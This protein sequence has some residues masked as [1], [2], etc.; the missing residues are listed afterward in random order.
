[1]NR[2]RLMKIFVGLLALTLIPGCNRSPKPGDRTAGSD[3]QS[4]N[5]KGSITYPP[6]LLPAPPK[7][8]SVSEGTPE[9]RAAKFAD[10]LASRETRLSGWLGVYDALRI[11]VIRQDGAAVGSTGDDPI[12]PRFWQVWYAS[13]LDLA[14]RGIP[15]NDAGRLMVVGLP[16]VDG[17]AFGEV[18]LKDLRLALQSSDPQERLLGK[19]VR[20]RVLRGS[21]GVDLANPAVTPQAAVI[22]LPTVQLLGWIAIRGV[23]FQAASLS[24]ETALA[25]PQT[26]AAYHLAAAL[27][28]VLGQGPSTQL[29]ELPQEP[30]IAERPCS[31]AFGGENSAYW[32][33]W[34]TNTI[35]GK[36]IELP[37]EYGKGLRGLIQRILIGGGAGEHTFFGKN[38]LPDTKFYQPKIRGES[39]KTVDIAGKAVHWASGLIS[40]LALALQISALDINPHQ[41]EPLVRTHSTSDGNKGNIV[42]VLFS[43]TEQPDDNADESKSKLHNCMLIYLSSMFGVS[44]SMPP[45][46]KIPGAAVKFKGGKGFPDLV[47]FGDYRDLSEAGKET[48]A[49]GE[50]TLAIIGKAQKRE[51]PKSAKPVDKEFSIFVSAQPEE[52]TSNTVVSV[53]LE[54]LQAPFNPASGL[55]AAVEIAKTIH[56]DL[57]EWYFRLTDWKQPFYKATYSYHG[58]ACDFRKPFI[59]F[60][61]Y[62][63]N[64][65]PGLIEEKFAFNPTSDTAGSVEF[66]GRYTYGYD[67]GSGTYRIDMSDPDHPCSELTIPETRGVKHGFPGHTRVPDIWR[68]LCFEPM[69]EEEAGAC[70]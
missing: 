24:H 62:P 3:S 9:E 13:G 5:V 35:V 32:A 53:F 58:Q 30:L 48:D 15:L 66:I 28:V 26:L 27:P 40:A 59:I 38:S 70:Q 11:P 23:V 42:W 41:E 6:P 18:L 17:S 34:L 69:T 60:R 22:D 33:T 44:F 61:D 51:I 16:G 19:F 56:Y 55:S 2:S 47:L 37:E 68:G 14:K 7:P 36:G 49:N 50:V 54:G 46:G 45:R 20:E 4:S 65:F 29:T 63:P 12:G 43:Q 8:A 31:E 67:N 25:R 21:S 10:L 57:G 1:M 52:V 39:H 64:F